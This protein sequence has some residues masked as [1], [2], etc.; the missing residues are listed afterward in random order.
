MLANALARSPEKSSISL[1]D[2][3]KQY[4]RSTKPIY[5]MRVTHWAMMNRM[6]QLPGQQ[7]VNERIRLVRKTD[8]I[9]RSILRRPEASY[10]NERATP[11]TVRKYSI[12]TIPAKSFLSKRS[13]S[14][15]PQSLKVWQNVLL[16]AIIMTPK[17]PSS[18]IILLLQVQDYLNI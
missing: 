3:M 17:T 12:I 8:E 4:Q 11:Q 18:I 14:L 13:E 6:C 2:A 10:L 9:K 7:V 1:G 16:K 5:K 15:F